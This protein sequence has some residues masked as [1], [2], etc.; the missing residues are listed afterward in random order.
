[1]SDG[2]WLWV[3]AILWPALYCI[4]LGAVI[5][6]MG[7]ASMNQKCSYYP[8]GRLSE[9]RIRST[10]IGTGETEVA[11]TDCAA[12]AYSTRGTGISDNGKDTLGE[13]AE[14]AVRGVLPLPTDLYMDMLP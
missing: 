10:V 8:D 4:G 12:L 7:C 3:Q 1:M 9:Y 2:T 11:T 14:G 13:I 5:W 6:L